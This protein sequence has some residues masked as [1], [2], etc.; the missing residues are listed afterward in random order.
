MIFPQSGTA[1][2]KKVKGAARVL[3]LPLFSQTIRYIPH[4]VRTLVL[5]AGESRCPQY[6]SIAV[7]QVNVVNSVRWR[8]PVRDNGHV[9]KES[10]WARPIAMARDNDQNKNG[11]H[12]SSRLR[13]AR[14]DRGSRGL[15]F[16]HGRLHG[17]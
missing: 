1:A 11:D 6:Y 15:E 14:Q 7:L 5:S 2:Q 10:L 17:V 12:S 4:I 16:E 9:C 8:V 13:H 3:F